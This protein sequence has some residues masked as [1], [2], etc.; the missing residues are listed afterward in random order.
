MVLEVCSRLVT[1]ARRRGSESRRAGMSLEA[2]DVREAS[3][4]VVTGKM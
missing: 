3:G 1:A 2:F 4:S